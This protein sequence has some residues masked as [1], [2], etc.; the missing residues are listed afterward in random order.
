M[1]IEFLKTNW[2]KMISIITGWLSKKSSSQSIKSGDKSN[3]NQAGRDINI[4]NGGSKNE[5]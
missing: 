5:R 3:N 4:T 1:I 2:S